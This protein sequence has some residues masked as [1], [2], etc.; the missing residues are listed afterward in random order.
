LPSVAYRLLN[1]P[2]E[3]EFLASRDPL[4]EP[5]IFS[6]VGYGVTGIDQS[7]GHALGGGIQPMGQAAQVAG[8]ITETSQSA[9]GAYQGLKGSFG[10]K[11]RREFVERNYFDFEV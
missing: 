5:N 7:T 3:F 9:I 2:R 11:E 8:Q 4:P 1:P 6:E 10:K